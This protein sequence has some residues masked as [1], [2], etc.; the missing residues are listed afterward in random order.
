M[1]L[2]FLGLAVFA[3]PYN[4]SSVDLIVRIDFVVKVT[5]RNFFQN[6]LVLIIRVVRHTMTRIKAVVTFT[7]RI[8]RLH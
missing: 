4:M 2:L 3:H 8:V 1:V 6:V 5:I 7:L